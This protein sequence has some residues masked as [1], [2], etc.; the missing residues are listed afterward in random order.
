MKFNCKSPTINGGECGQQLFGDILDQPADKV[1]RF[2]L[3]LFRAFWVKECSKQ[4]WLVVHRSC[5]LGRG[6][7]RTGLRLHAPVR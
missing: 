1:G 3:F 4:I 7:E 6:E 5:S 2:F